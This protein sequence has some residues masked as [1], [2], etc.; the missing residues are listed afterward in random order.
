MTP[1]LSRLAHRTTFAA[2]AGFACLGASATEGGGNTY[3]I[4]VETN[5]PGFMLPEGLHVMTYYQHY[6]ASHS[7]DGAGNDNQ[8]LAYYKFNADVLAARFSYVWPGVN[9]LGASVE[10]RAVLSLPTLD[11][12]LG[13]ARKAPLG[14]LDR[15]GSRTAIGD[16]MLAPLLLGWHSDKLH[17]TFGIEGFLPTGSYDKGRPVNSGRNYWQLAVAYGATWF[18]IKEVDLSAKLRYAVNGRNRD[19]D[20]RS[21]NE[22]SVEYSAGYRF[23]SAVAAGLSGYLYRQTTDDKQAGKLVNGDGNR[24]SVNAIGPYLT[25]SFNPKFTVTAKLQKEF[26]ARNKAEGTRLW[27]QARVPF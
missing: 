23:S 17:Q 9:W 5:F 10:T 12:T 20:Y 25:Y 15:S 7:K 13:V 1:T 27:L 8:R 22:L 24:G 21:G 16:F 14:P 6:S 4:G 3:P 2:A 26:G 18:P 19:T 11:L